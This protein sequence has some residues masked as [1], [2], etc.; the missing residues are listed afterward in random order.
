MKT[1]IKKAAI[2]SVYDFHENEKVFIGD[3]IY[4]VVTQDETEQLPPEHRLVST[5]IEKQN[6]LEFVTKK[7]AVFVASDEP[8]SFELRLYEF[9]TL[10]EFLLS[11]EELLELRE[12]YALEEG[13]SH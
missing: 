1:F 13:S 4:G 11:P 2:L 5:T 8:S 3:T 7:G 9:V 10:R 6:G 12:R